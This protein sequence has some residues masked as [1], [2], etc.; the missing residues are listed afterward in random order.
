MYIAVAGIDL[1]VNIA[2]K[3]VR[4]YVV[5][6]CMYEHCLSNANQIEETLSSTYSMACEPHAHKKRLDS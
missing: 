6:M 4:S 1:P 2:R 3:Q 5:C